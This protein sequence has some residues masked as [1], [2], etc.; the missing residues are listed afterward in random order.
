MEQP[1]QARRTKVADLCG[2]SDVLSNMAAAMPKDS[3]VR[4]F[5]SA[6]LVFSFV[7]KLY[8]QDDAPTG[9]AR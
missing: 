9:T 4:V 1:K 7:A 6:T 8:A 5:C 2:G 3:F